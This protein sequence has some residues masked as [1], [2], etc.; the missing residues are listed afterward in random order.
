ML[1]GTNIWHANIPHEIRE[2]LKIFKE[3]RFDDS[4]KH[5]E[6]QINLRNLMRTP[7]FDDHQAHHPWTNRSL[8]II[9][10][11][12]SIQDLSASLISLI[13]IELLKYAGQSFPSSTSELRSFGIAY[14]LMMRILLHRRIHLYLR[15]ENHLDRRCDL[16]R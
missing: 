13:S 14:H 16:D 10:D 6:R 8:K 12:K 5:I 2:R 9:I 1:T 11:H 3:R 4:L 7:I 15:G